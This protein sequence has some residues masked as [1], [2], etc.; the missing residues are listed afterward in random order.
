M[1]SHINRGFYNIVIMG[2]KFRLFTMVDN[3]FPTANLFIFERWC[4]EVVHPHLEPCAPGSHN[5]HHRD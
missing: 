5:H 2:I 3:L 4:V 1:Q